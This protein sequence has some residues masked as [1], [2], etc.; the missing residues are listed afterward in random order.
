MRS[1][2]KEREFQ[3]KC[4]KEVLNAQ[5]NMK[6]FWD[7]HGR[8]TISKFSKRVKYWPRKREKQEKSKAILQGKLESSPILLI[9]A[10]WVEANMM[11]RCLSDVS[12]E[13]GGALSTIADE[14]CKFHFG[15]IAGKN[16]VHVQ[17]KDMAAY[18]KDGSF[19]TI[20]SILKRYKPQL[21][22]S[23]GVAFGADAQKQNLGD[24]IVSKRLFPYDSSNKY[25]D[26]SIKLNGSLYETNSRLLCSWM[27]LLECEKF[28]GV[29][30]TDDEDKESANPGSGD[31]AGKR[32]CHLETDEFNWYSGTVLSGG[33]VV[34]EVEQ[35][36][37]LLTAAENRG[38]DDVVGGEMEGSGIYFA[39]D[40]EKIPCIVIKGIC[41]WGVN[42]NAWDE[43][44]KGERNPPDNQTVKD[45]IQ[46]LSFS[47]AFSALR[48]LLEYDNTMIEENYGMQDAADLPT[49][50]L[51][52]MNSLKR[53]MM[54]ISTVNFLP[55]FFLGTVCILISFL[56]EPVLFKLFHNE[57]FSENLGNKINPFLF[58][59]GGSLYI[60][61]IVWI[62]ENHLRTRPENLKL[63]FADISFKN[64]SFEKCC[65]I[66]ENVSKAE[67]YS[68]SIGWI[69]KTQLSP[70][71]IHKC[72]SLS[73]RGSLLV[74]SQNCIHN[75]GD[76]LVSKMP[77]DF[78]FIIPDTLQINYRMPNGDSV[79]H[80]I[81]KAPRKITKQENL[82]KGEFCTR[83]SEQILIYRDGIY[84]EV[85]KRI[86]YGQIIL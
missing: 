4:R 15:T 27:D 10:N 3:E 6:N 49:I 34:D 70:V 38:I 25:S 39:C 79:V 60:G 18:T 84:E 61:A 62:I 37:K 42:K 30:V 13:N 78:C 7:V 19:S 16:V 56:W 44:L 40:R 20:D 35:K 59:Y 83:Y 71:K 1:S 5:A 55:Y 46:A 26:G 69:C 72:K 73:S 75:P 80:I 76:I 77:E 74:T 23:V 64:L 86:C 48:C 81:S 52:N 33:S 24:V 12:G 82:E 50:H 63:V 66:L 31:E 57:I 2:K 43:I 54:K 36:V 11:V 85:L 47:H 9:T 68:M 41:D 14:R 45:C 32:Q 58:I 17:P 51:S 8:G 67:L 65:C 21:V 53:S 29:K 22:V 28:P